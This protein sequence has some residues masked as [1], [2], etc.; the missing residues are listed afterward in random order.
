M[1]FY[2]FLQINIKN[3]GGVEIIL[4]FEIK[5]ASGFEGLLFKQNKI[6]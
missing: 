6:H 5:K 4:I 3:M 1:E 2:I